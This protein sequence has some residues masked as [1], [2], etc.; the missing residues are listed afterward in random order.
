MQEVLNKKLHEYIK[1]NHPELLISLQEEGKVSKY[2]EEKMATADDLISCLQSEDTP[3][4]LIEEQCLEF[5]TKDLGPSKFSYI[6]A[7]LEEDFESEYARFNETGILTYEV[8][9]LIEACAPVFET[10][11]FS[12]YNQD[13]RFLRYATTGAISQYLESQ[14]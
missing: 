7:I 10:F 4:Y 5:L 1:S 13:D 2:L 12:S 3:A 6:L 11:G 8:I 9:N 14:Q